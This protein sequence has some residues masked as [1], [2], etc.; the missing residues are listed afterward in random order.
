MA[1]LKIYVGDQGHGSVH[2]LCA[3]FSTLGVF[4]GCLAPF[5]ANGQVWGPR[6]MVVTTCFMQG[7]V[8]R[9]RVRKG[10]AEERGGLPEK[11]ERLHR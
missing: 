6:I 10:V 8:A 9:M 2:P 4:F 3:T 11:E 7:K 1:S 5:A